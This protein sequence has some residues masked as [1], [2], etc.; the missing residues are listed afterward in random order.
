MFNMIYFIILTCSSI[1][2]CL[3]HFR[4]QFQRVRDPINFYTWPQFSLSTPS[5]YLISSLPDLQSHLQGLE[6]VES[7][8]PK[9]TTKS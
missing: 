4:N 3:K 9:R 2:S 8:T 7:F 6:M 5:S 1:L